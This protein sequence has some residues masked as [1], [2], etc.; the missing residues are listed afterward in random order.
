M[1][2]GIDGG[3]R[4]KITVLIIWRLLSLVSGEKKGG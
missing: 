2:T 4:P 1:A 3:S